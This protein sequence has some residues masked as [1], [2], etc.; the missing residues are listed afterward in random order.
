MKKIKNRAGFVEMSMI[1]YIIIFAI[2]AGGLYLTVYP[3]LK[4]SVDTNTYK[5]EFSTITQGLNQ[6][7]SNNYQYPKATGWGWD[8]ADTYIVKGIKA[9]GW[10]YSCSGSTITITT[11]ALDAKS[12]QRL[13]ESFSKSAS[14]VV[15][16]GNS[17]KVSLNNKPCP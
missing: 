8:S 12:K 11:P 5:S 15:S 6:Y 17:L 14:A 1:L 4:S 7:Y 9:K 2:I 10:N 3:S 13:S 16:S